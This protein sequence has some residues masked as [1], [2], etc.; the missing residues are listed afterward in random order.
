MKNLKNY[1]TYA[2]YVNAGNDDYVREIKPGVAYAKDRYV[3]GTRPF[4]FYNAP[5]E[6]QEGI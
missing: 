6:K 5:A 3:S 1:E 2:E 4:V